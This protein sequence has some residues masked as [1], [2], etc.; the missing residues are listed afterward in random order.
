MDVDK[1]VKCLNGALKWALSGNEVGSSLIISVRTFSR[2]IIA[3]RWPK[4]NSDGNLSHAETHEI[5]WLALCTMQNLAKAGS[6]PLHLAQVITWSNLSVLCSLNEPTCFAMM[7]K[8]IA[9][10]AQY[11]M[12]TLSEGSHYRVHAHRP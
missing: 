8:C 1:Q 9:Q 7:I 12:R 11:C 10:P 4:V 6:G 3:P 5:L 2:S